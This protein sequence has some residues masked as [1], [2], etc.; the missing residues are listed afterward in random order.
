MKMQVFC[1]R[2][3]ASDQYGNPMFLLSSGQALR[4]FADEVNRAAS[5]NLMFQHPDD[6]DLYYLGEFDTSDGVFSCK[7]PE[8]VAVGKMVKLLSGS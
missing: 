1:V 6:F 8:Q 2:D 4:S 3:R 5:D 7:A